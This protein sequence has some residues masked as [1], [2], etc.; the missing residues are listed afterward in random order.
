MEKI[1][2]LKEN[3]DLNELAKLQYDIIPQTAFILIKFR[4]LPL[5]CELIQA[6]I[7]TLYSNPEWKAKFYDSH[8]KHFVETL[9]LRFHKDG[10]IRYTA[11]FKNTVTAWRVQIDT[12]DDG[13]VGVTSADPDDTTIYYNKGLLEKF[14]GEEIKELLD[15]NLIEEIEVD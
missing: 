5:D 7:K 3:V 8:K 12:S 13:W 4:Q 15:N 1:Y 9:G 2:K 6:K 10:T 11:R 14:F